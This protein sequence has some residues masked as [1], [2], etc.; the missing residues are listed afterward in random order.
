[1]TG[2]IMA[3]SGVTT[4][5]PTIA[6]ESA[7]DVCLSRDDTEAELVGRYTQNTYL[8]AELITLLE[9]KC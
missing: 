7:R 1:M 5:A 9:D 4:T 6:Q 8:Q 3:D 2:M